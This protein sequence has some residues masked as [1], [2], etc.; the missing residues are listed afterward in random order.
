MY[1]NA[2]NQ[3]VFPIDSN[4]KDTQSFVFA[5]QYFKNIPDIKIIDSYITIWDT[6]YFK[7]EIWKIYMELYFVDAF[8]GTYLIIDANSSE[9]EIS[10]VAKWC[11]DICKII[12]KKKKNE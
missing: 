2:H 9:S 11:E 7:F 1:I 12:E 10:K 3:I 6:N 8:L 5:V 4:T